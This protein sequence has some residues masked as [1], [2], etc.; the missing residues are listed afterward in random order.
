[1]YGFEGKRKKN[2]W[3]KF[4]VPFFYQLSKSDHMETFCHFISLSS[5]KVSLQWLKS[6]EDKLKAFAK[7]L[8]DK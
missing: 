6:N 7:W 3:W 5:D 4:Y 2:I 8:K 1:M